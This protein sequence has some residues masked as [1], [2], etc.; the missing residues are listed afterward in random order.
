MSTSQKI[1]KNVAIAFA[2]FL[3]ITIFS[4]I[5]T[6]IYA[7]TH[8]F[9]KDN[10]GELKTYEIESFENLDIDIKYTNINIKN[11]DKYIIET[12]NSNIEL[13][14]NGN[15]L[16]IIE[17][18]H[19]LFKKNT[20]EITIYI[21]SNLEEVKINNGAGNL[22]IESLITNKLNLNLGAGETII[23]N[24]E[25]NSSYIDTG[26]G[27]FKI[28]NGKLNNLD[29]NMGIGETIITSIMS[30]NS[31]LDTGIG[32]LELNLIGTDYKLK[33]NKGIGEITVDNKK[34]KDN[35]IIGNGS[36]IISISGGIGEIK[37]QHKD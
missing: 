4:S 17:K 24:I 3:I 18:K 35:E 9:S 7:I 21:P 8:I 29:F 2:I 31:N 6:G 10:V 5:L 13:K 20:G 15:N 30:G 26:I 34:V 32:S 1:I 12:N 25:S 36:N 33:I 27:S 37:I 16:N 11:G 14:E 28:N 19:N 23:D 22:Y